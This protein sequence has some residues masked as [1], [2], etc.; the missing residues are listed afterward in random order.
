MRNTKLEE[1]IKQ[2]L[3]SNKENKVQTI[4]NAINASQHS[5]TDSAKMLEYIDLF[6]KEVITEFK[7]LKRIEEIVYPF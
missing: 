6:K 1:L 2:T 5:C 4:S 3:T 7:C